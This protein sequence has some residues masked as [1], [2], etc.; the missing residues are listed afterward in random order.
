MVKSETN[1][2]SKESS[3]DSSSGLKEGAYDDVEIV[4]SRHRT[5]YRYDLIAEALQKGQK[6]VLAPNLSKG[7]MGRILSQVRERVG[8]GYEVKKG[9]LKSD[10]TRYVL[11][12]TKTKQ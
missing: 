12:A 1:P 2:K 10:S 3:S 5:K 7:K 6:W 8:N 11:F 9:T 4:I